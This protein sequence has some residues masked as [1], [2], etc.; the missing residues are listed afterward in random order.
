MSETDPELTEA[1]PIDD[2]DDGRPPPIMADPDIIVEL[3]E[4]PPPTEYPPD[5]PGSGGDL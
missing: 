2:P 3:P 1:A 4:V 5:P